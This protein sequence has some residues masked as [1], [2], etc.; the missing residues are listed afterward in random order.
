MHQEKDD[1]KRLDQAQVADVT[2]LSDA[3]LED[4]AGRVVINH[5]EQR[6]KPYSLIAEDA[7]IP[8]IH[9]PVGPSET[10]PGDTVR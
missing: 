5:E 2:E 4:A 1:E 9:G 6:P 3:E 7:D 8:E 10:K